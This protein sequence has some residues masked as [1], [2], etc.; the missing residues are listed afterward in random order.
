MSIADI[1]LPP[2]A[3]L[4]V[5]LGPWLIIASLAVW[6]AIERANHRADKQ[7]LL[8]AAERFDRFAADV[9]RNEADAR[10]ADQAHARAVEQRQTAITQEVSNDYEVKLADAHAAV[11]AYARRNAGLVRQLAA[12]GD[13]QSGGGR[14][15]M[16]TPANAAG[17]P[18]ARPAL[19]V[20][21]VSDLHTCA[22]ALAA[23]NG[24]QDWWAKQAGVER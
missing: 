22:D 15:D 19:T 23:V 4:A 3:K 20:V 9:K 24:W 17:G 1:V 12:A 18:D 11:D 16:P 14:T 7:A 10:A 5:K 2:W 6:L 8:A 21:P 13:D